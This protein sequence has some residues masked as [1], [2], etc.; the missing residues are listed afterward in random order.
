MRES[1]EG[2]RGGR[3]GQGRGEGGGEG[4]KGEGM[5]ACMCAWGRR[6]S[7]AKQADGAGRDW[8]Q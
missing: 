4:V 1:R 3:G 7:E 5:H 6:G 8:D 2:G